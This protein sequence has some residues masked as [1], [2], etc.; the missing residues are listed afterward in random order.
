MPPEGVLSHH[1][2]ALGSSCSLFAVGV[3]GERLARGEAWV[4]SLQA[5]LTRFEPDS[6]LS[7]LNAAAGT[8]FTVSDEL[9][10]LLRESLLA[11]ELSGGLVNVA[12]LGAMHRIGYRRSLSEVPAGRAEPE[13]AVGLGP[14][15]DLLEVVP[16]RARLARGAGLDLGGL[17]KGWLA[18]RLA[19]RLGDNAIANL[20]GD[21]FALGAGPAGDGWPVEF[22]GV[23]VLLRDQGAA[24]SSTLKR[25]WRAGRTAVHHLIDPRTGGPAAGD[26]AEVSVVA[27]SAVRAEVFAK[28]AL[29]LGADAAP[30]YLAA[31][32]QAWHLA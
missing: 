27:S 22:G 21:L 24:T 31:N 6:E 9:E 19:E 26:L 3:A 12:V 1:F 14:L 13:P 11:W 10:D 28:T 8:W 4:R 16:G 17:A 32:S 2:E 18:D 25:A 30:L 5:R 29:L 23:T 15:P 7:R 20:G